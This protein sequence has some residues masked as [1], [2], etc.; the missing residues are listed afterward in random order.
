M[1][2]MYEYIFVFSCI[3]ISSTC[4]CIHRRLSAIP[5]E[6]INVSLQ[7]KWYT[8]IPDECIICIEAY[9]TTDAIRILGCNHI[10]HTKC[11]ETWIQYS[12]KTQCP[13]CSKPL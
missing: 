3:V 2:Y 13:I 6:D 10:F 8:E 4:Y 12:S 1:Y 11:I 7:E 9:D 5:T